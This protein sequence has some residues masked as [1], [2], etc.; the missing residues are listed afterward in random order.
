MDFGFSG[1]KYALSNK[2]GINNRIWKRHD[3]DLINDT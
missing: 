2:R 1:Q 3:R